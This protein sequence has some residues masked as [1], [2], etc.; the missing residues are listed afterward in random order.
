MPTLAPPCTLTDEEY[1]LLGEL[2]A[3]QLG[4]TLP[5]HK[6][7]MLAA[8]LCSRLQVLHLPRFLDYY[9]RLQRDPQGELRWL[10]ELVTNNETYFFREVQQFEALFAELGR[11]GRTGRPARVLCAGCSSGEEPYTLAI[12]GWQNALRPGLGRLEIDAFDVD[13]ARIEMASAGRY[14]RSSLR[15]TTPEQMRLCFEPAGGDQWSLRAPFRTGVRFGWGNILD[16]GSFPSHGGG[17]DAVFCRNVLIYFSEAAL[18]RAVS[19]FIG[20][21]RPGGL[22]FLGLAESI[23]G[24]SDRLETVRFARTIAYRKVAA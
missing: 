16:P 23:I 19:H 24:L 9:L 13:A 2:V 6:R 17:Y 18:R 1:L 5:E 22:L 14:G 20:A 3:K 15:A 10:A 12:L 8:R 21:L 11:G 4:I 7:E